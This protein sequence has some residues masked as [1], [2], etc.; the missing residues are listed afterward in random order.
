MASVSFGVVR[1]RRVSQ[2]MRVTGLVWVVDGLVWAADY[3]GQGDHV[4]LQMTCTWIQMS[5]IWKRA[6]LK[7]RFVHTDLRATYSSFGSYGKGGKWFSLSHKLWR[8]RGPCIFADDLHLDTD[9]KLWR[10]RG[11]YVF[12]DGSH[13]CTDVFHLEKGSFEIFNLSHCSLGYPPFGSCGKG[14]RTHMEIFSHMY[15]NTCYI[16]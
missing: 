6:S 13:L 11:S 4:Y 8:P 12:T 1:L 9:H 14:G 3:E 7:S 2:I 5:F 16:E 15:L 10:P